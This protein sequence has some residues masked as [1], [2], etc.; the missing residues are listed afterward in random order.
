MDR[1]GLFRAARE[2]VAD[3][4]DPDDRRE[5]EQLL[6]QGDATALAVR[7][8]QPLTFGTAGLRGPMRAGPN[9]INTATVSRTAA[10]LARFLPAGPRVVVGHDARHRSRALALTCARVLAGAGCP[11]ELLDGA[12]PTPLLAFAVRHLGTDAGVMIT[13][14]HNPPADN[15][16]KVYLGGPRGDPGAGAQIAPPT[17]REIEDAI[18]AVGSVCDLPH[19]EPATVSAGSLAEAY[20]D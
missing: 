2:W 12:A 3:D 20:L 19:A 14:S 11:V 6:K 16:V 1:S 9:G 13:A 15:G 8:D 5:L 10:G 18:A 4:P 7:F 17:D